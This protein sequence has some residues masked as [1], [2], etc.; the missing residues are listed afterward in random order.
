MYAVIMAGGQGTRL[1]PLS[2]KKKPK[3]LHALCGDKPLIRETY[4]RLK[5]DFKDE[6]IIVS[7]IPDFVKDIK[8]CLPEI[9]DS[10]Y[11]VE[12][13]L[14]GN[15]AACCLVSKLL[16]DRNHNSSAVFLPADHTITNKN[17]FL[18]TINFAEKVLNENP[19]HIITIGINPT[20]PDINLGYIQTDSQIKEMENLKAFTVKKFIEKPNLDK[21]KEYFSSWEFL[22]NAGVFIWRNDHILDLY[23]QNL[24]KT[25]VHIGKIS[26]IWDKNDQKIVSKEYENVDNTSVDYAIIE[27]TKDIIVI[28]AAFDWSDVGS[29]G[30]LYEVLSNIKGAK[31]ISKGNHVSVDD[32]NCLVL[33]S[34]KLIATI[35]LDDIVI[36]DTPDALL[37]C[38]NKESHKIKDLIKNLKNNNKDN[39]L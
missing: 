6:D 10:N 4:E 31:V 7:T 37:V 25:Y 9:P 32:G 3:Q 14:M 21:A 24:V 38:N 15:A 23:R 27:K 2:R 39:Y 19:K 20:K 36:V 13:S 26:K 18:K 12:P 35:G 1:W 22:W 34:D 30:S 28:P 17:G 16:Y 29:W 11:I 33:G 5:P 8:K